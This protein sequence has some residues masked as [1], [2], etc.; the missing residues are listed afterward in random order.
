MHILVAATEQGPRVSLE[1]PDD[2]T[3]FH[4]AVQGLA[5]EA[6]ARA[7]ELAG[8]GTLDEADAAWIRVVA[9]RERAEGRVAGDWAE[10]FHAMLAYAGHKGW[11][12][13]DQKSVQGHCEWSQEG[14]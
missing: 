14:S 12:S 2:C 7:I 3:R 11:L 4:V 8:V 6:A 9:L 13:E 10:R 1:E 5:R